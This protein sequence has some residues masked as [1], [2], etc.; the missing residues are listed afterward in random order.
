MRVR[1]APAGEKIESAV[2]H[3]N[4]AGT[5]YQLKFF[6]ARGKIGEAPNPFD[7]VRAAARARVRT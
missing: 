2:L 3:S 7:L 5:I 4:G 1:R 6:S